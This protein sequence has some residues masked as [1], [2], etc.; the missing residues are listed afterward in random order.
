MYVC[1]LV[2][3]C[4][5]LCVCVCMCVCVCVCV[6]VCTGRLWVGNPW[7]QVAQCSLADLRVYTKVLDNAAVTRIFNERRNEVGSRHSLM[8]S[9]SMAPIYTYPSFHH[10]QYSDTRHLHD[11][12]RPPSVKCPR[13]PWCVPACWPHRSRWRPPMLSPTR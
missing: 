7:Q 3:V 2:C 11:V 1:V 12:F 4:V 13:S 9:Y 10:R 8:H 6:C 5:Y